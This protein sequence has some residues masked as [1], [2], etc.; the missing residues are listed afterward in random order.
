MSIP[1]DPICQIARGGMTPPRV[2][3]AFSYPSPA[4]WTSRHR[5]GCS[6]QLASM[7]TSAPGAQF[8]IGT[9][10]GD[11]GRSRPGPRRSWRSIESFQGDSIS[12]ISS[13]RASRQPAPLP[14]DTHKER[15]CQDEFS[16]L[17]GHR[18]APAATGGLCSGR[19]WGARKPPQPPRRSTATQQKSRG[20]AR[21]ADNGVYCH[22]NTDPWRPMTH[23]P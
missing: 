13:R 16:S 19:G 7:G 1:K 5:T 22:Q 8:L 2:D 4:E 18:M 11:T 12:Q 17:S 3:R 14:R 6:F 15:H 20:V 9:G 10:S 23:V 21:A